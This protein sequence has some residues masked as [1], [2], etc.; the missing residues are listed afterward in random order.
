MI[1]Y[2]ITPF[3]LG[4]VGSLTPP[5]HRDRSGRNKPEGGE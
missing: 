5:I 1:D 2:C 3:A 4:S